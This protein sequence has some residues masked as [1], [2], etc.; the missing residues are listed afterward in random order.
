MS[1]SK[2]TTHDQDCHPNQVLSLQHSVLYLLGVCQKRL[3]MSSSIPC[4]IQDVCTKTTDIIKEPL[5]TL[6]LLEQQLADS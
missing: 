2:K 1:V 3:I 6:S 4:A 5:S